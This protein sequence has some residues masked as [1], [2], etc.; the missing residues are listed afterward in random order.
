MI[1]EYYRAN[2]RIQ[3]EWHNLCVE[4]SSYERWRAEQLFGKGK[5]DLTFS[6]LA[7]KAYSDLF[8]LDLAEL[9]YCTP[10]NVVRISDLAK[11][12]SQLLPVPSLLPDNAQKPL[13]RNA[14]EDLHN[15]RPS[16]LRAGASGR[17]D[18]IRRWLI[19]KIAEEFCYKT[20]T[21]PTVALVGD[22]IRLGWSKTSDRSIRNTLTD[23]L[24]S[25][26]MKVANVRREQLNQSTNIAHQA[27]AK[28]SSNSVQIDEVTC[29]YETIVGNPSTGSEILRE[30]ERLAVNIPEED[31]RNRA[32]SFM[33]ALHDEA[34]YPQED[35][36]EGN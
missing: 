15:W 7:A 25:E 5:F 4:M 34:G 20:A 33:Q 30:M 19:R 10:S 35:L 23:E 27:I 17:G 2:N 21:R 13:F 22:L 36:G 1:D 18:P 3:S 6:G 12:L 32:L 28:V 8:N 31:I 16:D 11:L 26:V 14:L 24:L 29:E 9:P